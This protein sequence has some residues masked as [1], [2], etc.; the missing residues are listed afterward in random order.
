MYRR[1]I[2]GWEKVLGKE[3]YDT[4]TSV[5]SLGNTLRKQSKYAEA[6]A[7]HRRALKGREKALGKEHPD[8]LT[9]VNNLGFTLYN[10]SKYAE[11]E[12]EP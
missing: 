12:D 1:V 7:V 4:L 8:T 3:H 2:E 5:N 6:E 10:Q 11:A 9:S